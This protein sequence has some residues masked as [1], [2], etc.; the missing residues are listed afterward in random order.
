VARLVDFADSRIQAADKR[1]AKYDNG[2]GL[3]DED[4]VELRKP[5]YLLPSNALR[6]AEQLDRNS[7]KIQRLLARTEE[8][9][10]DYAS[11]HKRLSRL[12][13]SFGRNQ[14]DDDAFFSHEF[15]GWVARN[16][17]E[18]EL[19]SN[20]PSLDSEAIQRL[21][22]EASSDHDYCA[23]FLKHA[24]FG[25]S[26]V[27]KAYYVMWHKLKAMVLL[28]EVELKRSLW[29]DAR[30]NIEEG[31]DLLERLNQ[32]IKCA[33]L[34]VEATKD[35]EHRLQAG[36]ERLHSQTLAHGVA[37]SGPEG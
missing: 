26:Q 2:K 18:H 7:G 31:R 4:R 34:N 32:Y 12:I 8:I 9:Y 23:R 27:V 19:N 1:A 11:S 29:D 30:K 16:W 35:I 17:A 24:D 20:G 33:E 14:Q 3:K 25:D 36:L 13:N 10:G 21:L 28:A 15:R 22:Q 6:L 37:T 5:T